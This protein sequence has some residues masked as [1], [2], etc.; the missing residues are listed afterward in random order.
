MINKLPDYNR[1]NFKKDLC[2]LI[3]KYFTDAD[4]SVDEVI[5]LFELGYTLKYKKEIDNHK[6]VK[7]QLDTL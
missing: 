6:E 2:K 1:D 5:E 7:E 4:R 3:N